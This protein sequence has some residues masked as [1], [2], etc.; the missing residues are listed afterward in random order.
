MGG[1]FKKAKAFA[2]SPQGKKTM[3]QAQDYAK[4]P[5]GKKQISGLRSRFTKGGS[6]KRKP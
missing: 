2:S 3:R 5:E 6:G 4:S 1:L